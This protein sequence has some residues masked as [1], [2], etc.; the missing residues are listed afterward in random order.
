MKTEGP[1]CHKGDD[2]MGHDPKERTVGCFPPVVHLGLRRV[3]HRLK[4]LTTEFLLMLPRSHVRVGH[5]VPGCR[6]M[7]HCPYF[8]HSCSL[9]AV[10]Q[11]WSLMR[12]MRLCFSPPNTPPL[13]PPKSAKLL[14]KETP[15]PAKATPRHPLKLKNPVLIGENQ[16]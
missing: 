5:H 6:P 3:M 14:T 9:I 15:T 1:A 8:H 11:F 4:G 13:S 2:T 7:C 10:R 16:R 12:Y